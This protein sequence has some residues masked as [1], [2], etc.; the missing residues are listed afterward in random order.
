MAE[1]FTS[2][3][4]IAYTPIEELMQIE[5]FDEG[6]AGELQDR[7]LVYTEAERER[8]TRGGWSWA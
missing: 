4:E 6:V 7:A 8:L 5:G 2:V 1:G 3:D